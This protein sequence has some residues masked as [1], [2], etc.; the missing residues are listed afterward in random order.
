MRNIF[1][2][3]LKRADETFSEFYLKHVRERSALLAFFFHGLF[4]NDAE[5][6][7]AWADPLEAMTVARFRQ[8]VAYYLQ[9]GYTFITPDDIVRGLDPHAK[10]VMATFDDGYANNQ[11]A[12][13]ILQEFK[14]PAVFYIATNYVQRQRS[15]WW[16][17]VYRERIKRGSSVEA[18]Q[19]EQEWLKTK[20][21]AD[22]DQYIA[23]TFGA[24]A[25]NPCSDVERP[26]TPTE[27]RTFSQSPYVCVGNH[28]RD[29]AILTNYTAAEIYTQIADAQQ[30][31]QTMT[32]K[33]PQSIAYPNG[34]FNAEVLRV[35]KQVGLKLGLTVIAQKNYLPLDLSNEGALRLARFHLSRKRELL[36][37]CAL[38]R[39][40][41]WLYP[42]LR[43]FFKRGY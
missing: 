34:G 27:L 3:T 35:V 37:Q 12:L 26:L 22:I 17:V 28:T 42:K 41:V 1:L 23:N 14:I 19:R 43:N 29:H 32:G 39:S 4:Q 21:Y 18:I 15:F 11:R 6:D 31:L 24:Q 2:A 10:Y 13:P 16:D 40:D 8:F 30:A 33:L 5:V 25:F 38:I 20:T 36:R 7:A 9:H